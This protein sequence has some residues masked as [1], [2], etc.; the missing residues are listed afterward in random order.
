MRRLDSARIHISYQ[1]F[2]VARDL[3]RIIWFS[4]EPVPEH[5][6]QVDAEVFGVRAHIADKGLK[7]PAGSVKKNDVFAGP[8]LK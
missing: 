2:D 7:V 1:V 5:V 4:R 6:D 3:I 8:G